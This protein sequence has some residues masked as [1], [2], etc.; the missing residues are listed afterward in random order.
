MNFTKAELR[1][2]YRRRRKALTPQQIDD[3]SILIVN[4]CLE[5]KLWDQ[6]TYHLFMSFRKNN[7]IDTSLLLSVIQGKDK[8]PV[9]PKMV[10]DH[11]LEHYL[12][13]DQTPIKI[14]QWGIPEPQSGIKIDSEQIEVV[15]VP[16]LIFDLQGHRVGY[17]KGYYDRFL[18]KCKPGTIKV[19][20]SFF[21]P[22]E[23]IKDI[24]SHDIPIDFGV[25][26]NKSY[27]FSSF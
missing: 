1:I 4:R 10:G 20:L 9:I 11:D 24:E 17:G 7:E 23:R 5:L 27:E 13:L 3:L 2:Q 25:T 22:I 8:Q 12:L 15:F 21:D 16:L 6:S 14:N 18:A 19:G 26:P